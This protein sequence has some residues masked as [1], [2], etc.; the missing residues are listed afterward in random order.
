MDVPLRE[1][2][3][4][5]IQDGSIINI[6]GLDAF[7]IN[8]TENISDLGAD[9]CQL[10]EDDKYVADYALIWRYNMQDQKYHISLRSNPKRDI[11]VS[12]IASKLGKGGGHKNAAG[13]Q[14]KNIF[15]ILCPRERNL[16]SIEESEH[17]RHIRE[18][19]GN[20]KGP[21]YYTSKFLC[22]LFR[23]NV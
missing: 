16:L 18:Y 19:Y 21:W 23:K 7:V 6:D 13:F 12:E 4:L 1:R 2:N 11:D 22:W 14:C 10:K 15:R 20:I 3:E 8:T 5:L 17:N 9:I